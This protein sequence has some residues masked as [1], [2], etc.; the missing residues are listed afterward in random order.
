MPPVQMAGAAFPLP[1][2]TVQGQVSQNPI[3][4]QTFAS[5]H[6]FKHHWL[7]QMEA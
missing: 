5:D 3:G 7:E 1:E 4:P 6:I 2:Q